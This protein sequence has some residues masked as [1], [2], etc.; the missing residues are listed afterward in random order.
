MLFLALVAGLPQLWW[1]HPGGGSSTVQ[2]WWLQQPTY[3]VC[4]LLAQLIASKNSTKR[5]PLQYHGTA[6]ATQCM[7]AALHVVHFTLRLAP[8]LY[9]QVAA[10]LV[11]QALHSCTL[12]ACNAY[13]ASNLGHMY[14]S[15]CTSH[16]AFSPLKAIS[17]PSLHPL[18]PHPGVV[19]RHLQQFRDVN[20]ISSLL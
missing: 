15:L 16:S 14:R 8:E 10:E 1:L 9:L 2:L 7:C 18:R 6:A 13:S 11:A 17:I 4:A 12:H 20:S 3:C 19:S 5:A